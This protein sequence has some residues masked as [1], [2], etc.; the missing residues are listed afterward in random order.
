MQRLDPLNVPL[1]GLTL[2]EANAGTG[3]TWT[4]TA[5]YLRLLLEGPHAVNSILVVTFTDIATAELRD[6]IRSRLVQARTA[7]ENRQASSDDDFI[8]ALVQRV[9]NADE[10]LDRLTAALAGFDQA[11]VYTIHGFCQRVLGDRA[12]ESLMPFET[13]LVPDESLLLQ[14]IADDFWRK[15]FYEAPGLFVAYV[16]HAGLTPEVLKKELNGRIG[17][18]Y[19]EIRKPRAPEVLPDL[20]SAYEQAYAGARRIWLAERDR[21]EAQLTRNVDLSGSSYRP[22]YLAGWLQSMSVCLRSERPHLALFKRFEKFT[23]EAL[24][25]GTR[26]GGTPPSHPFYDAC[27]NLL[28]AHAG[29]QAAYEVRLALLRA[30]LLEYCNAELVSRKKR[31]GL[32]SYDDLLLNLERTLRSEVGGGL[33]AALRARYPAALIDEFQDTDPVQYQ[34]FRAIYQGS[35]LPAFLVGDPKQSIYSFRGA[36]VHAYLR[37]RGDAQH[38]HTLDVNWRSQRPLLGAVNLL[39]DGKAAPFVSRE[40]PFRASLA[41]RGNRGKC[42][43]DG[44]TGAPFEFWLI[45]SD[46]GKPLDK[47]EAGRFSAQATA[48]EIARLMRLGN[49]RR[50]SITMPRNG[51]MEE[52]PLS[53]GDIAVLV[54]THRQA[55]LVRD[56][57]RALGI[58]S[59][60]RGGSSVFQSAEADELQRVL[61]AV[62]EPAREMLVRAALLTE[63]MGYSGAEL[64][65]MLHDEARWEPVVET[66]RLAHIEWRDRGFIRMARAFLNRCGIVERML[67]Y[68]DG[69]RR[70][71]NLFHLIELV[72]REAGQCGISATLEWLAEKRRAPGRG[73][74][75]ELLRL[76][77]DENLVKILTVY[78]AKGLEFPLVFCPFV[79]DG[80]AP[81]ARDTA[82]SYHDPA[83]DY[84]AVLDLGSETM[85]HYRPLAQRERLAEDV[86]LLYVAL[87]RARFRC[88]MIWGHVRDAGHAAPAWVLHGSGTPDAPIPVPLSDATIVQDLRKIETRAEGNI[89]VQQISGDAGARYSSAEGQLPLLAPRT[90]AGAIGDSWRITS[91]SALAH[92]RSVETPDYDGAVLAPVEETADSGRDMHAFPRGARA[93]RCLHAIFQ[94]IDFADLSR[95]DTQRIVARELAA[96]DFASQWVPAVTDMVERVIATPLDD[97]G[98]VR[99]ADVTRDRRFD[100]LEFYYP[101]VNLKDASLR[102]LLRGSGFPD[103]I[104]QRID[105]LTFTAAHGYVKGYIDLVFETE[106]RFYLVDYK[107]NWLGATQEAYRSSELCKSMARETYYLQYLIYC[108]ALH[109]YL[110][111]RISDYEYD[112]RFGGVRYLFLRGMSPEFGSTRGVY[113]DRPDALLIE[114]LDALLG[115]G[116][117]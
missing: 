28:S 67:Q 23:N 41:A 84:A 56:A 3:K 112:A 22:D 69:E 52:R 61:M 89:K 81:S 16:M 71:T 101:I 26:R 80:R 58:A 87:T 62:A 85:E 33:A 50:A 91:F 46:N 35:A 30:E 73:I 27:D 98:R 11:P 1:D 32:Q 72:H 117:D 116:H 29:L 18:P 19:L 78:V 90:F 12:F 36:D 57:L 92:A 66:F 39:F 104:R 94:A 76:E 6:R 95:G 65:T 74:E 105:A 38:R 42:T 93:G 14:E 108:V 63:M 17:K 47:E 9:A 109:R 49:E 100:E 75:E 55:Q 114:K 53:G 60:D 21:I 59:V 86:R 103:E 70:V 45:P 77:S 54:R 10:A 37:A 97:T 4:I 110:K 2:I 24:R 25:K 7:F 111:S 48:S 83:R 64:D 113:V 13:R 31:R 102:A 44:E 8:A 99:L 15:S 88:W 5:L 40:I 34:I 20:E 115:G 68:G 82:I 96:H 106:G 79:W 51:R 43:L 107:S